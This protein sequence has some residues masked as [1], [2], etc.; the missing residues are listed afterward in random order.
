M[1]LHRKVWLWW[2]KGWAAQ[3]Y[4]APCASFGVHFD[5]RHPLLDLHMTPLSPLLLVSLVWWPWWVLLFSLL[6]LGVFTLAI[7]PASHITGQQDRHRQCCRG[8]LFADDPVL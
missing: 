3:Y 6:P 7:G 8:F 2:G 4:R 5:P 1:R